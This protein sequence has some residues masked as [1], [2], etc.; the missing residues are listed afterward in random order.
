MQI[1]LQLLDGLTP[2]GGYAYLIM[3]GILIACGFGLPIPED[4]VLITGGILAARGVVNF[5]ATFAVTMAGV[6]IG[7]GIVFAIGKRF[8]PRIKETKFFK[9]LLTPKREKKIIKWFSAYGDKVIFFARFAP[10]L[11]T[12]LFLTAGTYQ[13]PYWK[14][15]VLDGFAA[16]ISVPLWIWVGKVF[17]DNLDLLEVKIR[18][19]QVGM[20]S[21]L[22][23]LL[24][25]VI[26]IWYVKKQFKAKIET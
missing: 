14:F 10:G 23:L 15:F 3:F 18:K 20:Y 12:P 5:W 9:K 6:L 11:R 25:L 22:L 13:V 8:G 7:D 19:F 2:Y 16:L 17:G 1:I 26:I 4:V 24:A 21:I